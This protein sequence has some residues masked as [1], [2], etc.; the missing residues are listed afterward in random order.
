M[1]ELTHYED[2]RKALAIC[3][4]IDEVKDIQDKSEAMRLYA[5]MSENT[6]LEVY[7]STIKLRAQ[8]RLGEII[9]AMP[10]ASPPGIKAEL[11][12]TGRDI[13]GKREALANANISKSAAHRYEQLAAAPPHVIEDILSNALMEQ[14]PVTLPKVLS[15]INPPPAKPVTP[16]SPELSDVSTVQHIKQEETVPKEQHEELMA[17]VDDMQANVKAMETVI[18]ADDKLAAALTKIKHLNEEIRVTTIRLNSEMQKNLELTRVI[19]SKDKQIAV[20]N[21]RVEKL[22]VDALP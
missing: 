22:T 10:K 9:A 5:K 7:A 4:S 21:K 3:A 19:K 6:E 8:V 13:T 11:C 18:D 14:I 20:L 17:L 2:A 15:T 16:P 1:Y 12:P